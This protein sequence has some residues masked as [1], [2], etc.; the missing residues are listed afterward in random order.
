MIDV[1]VGFNC[2]IKVLNCN[3]KYNNALFHSFPSSSFLQQVP[4]QAAPPRQTH[5]VQLRHP[6]QQEVPQ[7]PFPQ[8]LPQV[9]KCFLQQHIQQIRT[10][11]VI[12][13]K[14]IIGIVIARIK[15]LS[16][17]AIFS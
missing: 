3:Y 7:A 13:S 17:S 8:V 14:P 12:K 5:G 4:Q 11:K 1:T 15:S 10:I 2:F 16:E 6:P 9:H